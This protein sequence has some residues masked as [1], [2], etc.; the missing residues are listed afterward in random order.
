MTIRSPLFPVLKEMHRRLK[1]ERLYGT[2]EELLTLKQKETLILFFEQKSGVKVAKTM[3]EYPLSVYER[4]KTALAIA[5]LLIKGRKL[6]RAGRRVFD[7]NTNIS[8]IPYCE[9][10]KIMY[11]RLAFYE[12]EPEPAKVEPI[13]NE[14]KPIKK[15]E[16]RNETFSV[17][18]TLDYDVLAE[19]LISTFFKKLSK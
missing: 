1:N 19:K 5:A 9:K 16:S 13:R 12:P 8:V 15:D 14:P 10:K 4:M 7:F 6:K 11:N 2:F 3:N 17:P 18:L